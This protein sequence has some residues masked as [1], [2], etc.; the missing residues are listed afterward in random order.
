MTIFTNKTGETSTTPTGGAFADGLTLMRFLLSP[1]IMLVIIQG[2]PNLSMAI[3]ASALFIIAAITDFF[4]DYFGGTEMAV[5]RKF[6][7]FDDIA[8]ITLVVSTLTAMLIVTHKSGLLAW[9]F[10]V[11]AGVIIL[12]EALVGVVK[13]YE[14][15]KTGWPETRYGDLKNGLV[16][17]GTCILLASPWLTTWIERSLAGPDN[18]M[19]IYGSTSPYVWL[20]G[21]AILWCAAIVSVATGFKILSTKTIDYKENDK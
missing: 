19:E 18:V 1:I 13:G 17:L 2:W 9:T 15:T 5:Y 8:D 3:L 7:W 16:M 20:I 10:L 6:G 11:P 21:E 14:M 4:D 12:R